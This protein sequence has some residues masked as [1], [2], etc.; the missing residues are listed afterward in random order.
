MA[1]ASYLTG[2][3]PRVMVLLQ[4]H[5]IGS[6]R[7]RRTMLPTVI[8]QV[9]T[10]EVAEVPIVIEQVRTEEGAEVEVPTVI[11]QV[12]TEEEAEAEDPT[13]IDKV[14]QERQVVLLAPEEMAHCR[15]A[16]GLRTKPR[17]LLSFRTRRSWRTFCTKTKSRSSLQSI[18]KHN[19]FWTPLP[20]GNRLWRLG[21]VCR[22][23]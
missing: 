14:V 19:P 16:Q 1:V 9:R 2:Q 3:L 20:K 18:R 23:W 5:V 21:L 13:V 6:L 4:V 7:R 11:E 15:H 8:E 10:E 12:R 22:I 17:H